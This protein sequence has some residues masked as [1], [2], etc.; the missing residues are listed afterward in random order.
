[1]GWVANGHGLGG[2]QAI[3]NNAIHNSIFKV[4]LV[5]IRR[6]N[7]NHPLGWSAKGQKTDSLL[8][9]LLFTYFLFQNHK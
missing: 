4:T 6:V 7:N 2:K 5:E 8:A 1:M 3:W 9:N